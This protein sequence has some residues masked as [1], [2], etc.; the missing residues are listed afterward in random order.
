[1]SDGP[2]Q[3][4]DEALVRISWKW[5]VPAAALLIGTPVGRTPAPRPVP[6]I[7]ATVS[8]VP[9]RPDGYTV[10]DAIEAGPV[11]RPGRDRPWATARIVDGAR[12]RSAADLVSLG[13]GKIVVFRANLEGQR[14]AGA[15]LADVCFAESKLARTDWRGVRASS[16]AIAGSDLTGAIMTG[17]DL[18]GAFFLD[19][20]LDRVDASRANL[21]NARIQGGS[22]DGLSLRDAG[23]SGF[24]MFCGLIV[25]DRNCGPPTGRGVDARGADL[26]A[27]HF[28]MYTTDGWKFDHAK[29]DRTVVQYL[30]LPSFRNA[31]VRGPV[32]LESSGY[33]SV[34][35]RLDPAEWRQLTATDWSGKPTFDCRRARSVAERLV[36]GADGVIAERSLQSRPAGSQAARR[37]SQRSGAG[38]RGGMPV[39]SGQKTPSP[40]ARTS[41]CPRLMTNASPNST[42]ACR[43]RRGYLPVERSCSFPPLPHRRQ[44]SSKA[45]YTRRSFRSWSPRRTATCSYVSSGATASVRAP[46]PGAATGIAAR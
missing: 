24:D 18:P 1:M 12:I 46:M 23:M 38:S 13:D 19:T 39:A 36:C 34:R 4:S 10:C 25:G 30:Q 3:I 31:D 17:A 27:A 33:E 35:A 22:F 26:S 44:R 40:A 42:G 16:V 2:L 14:L 45:R 15:R 6:R 20:A 41:A 29:L 7:A 28:N 9:A 5:I 11:G 21:R 8:A 37:R 43:F 32:M